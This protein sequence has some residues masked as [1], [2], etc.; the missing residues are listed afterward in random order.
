MN[1][2]K[3]ALY[4]VYI[5]RSY[6]SDNLPLLNMYVKKKQKKTNSSQESQ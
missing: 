1:L 4:T 3:A 2:F 6:N 5:S